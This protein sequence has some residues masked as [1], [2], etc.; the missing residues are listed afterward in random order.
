MLKKLKEKIFGKP[1][2]TPQDLLLKE[3]IRL[4]EE[5]PEDWILDGY[6]I[7]NTKHGISIWVANGVSSCDTYTEGSLPVKYFSYY[8]DDYK[9]NKY[10]AAL[11]KAYKVWVRDYLT[12]NILDNITNKE[13]KKQ[14]Q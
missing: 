13:K 3:I 7:Y 11:W 6:T 1:I 8:N 12:H 14:Q 2:E 5:T 9:V 10:K 4:F